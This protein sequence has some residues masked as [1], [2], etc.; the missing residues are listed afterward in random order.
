MV[1]LEFIGSCSLN[2]DGQKRFWWQY[3]T[4]LKEACDQDRS[5]PLRIIQCFDEI[6]FDGKR[7]RLPVPSEAQDLCYHRLNLMFA[8][9]QHNPRYQRLWESPVFDFGREAP[10]TRSQR[11]HTLTNLV[12]VNGDERACI[13]GVAGPV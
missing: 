11:L 4:T 5:F 3:L 8:A 1:F 6:L 9:L 12:R 7:F 2:Y 10:L 13:S